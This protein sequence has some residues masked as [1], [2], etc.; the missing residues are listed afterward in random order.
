MFGNDRENQER[1]SRNYIES[2]NDKLEN[3]QNMVNIL[4]SFY[5]LYFF[6]VIIVEIK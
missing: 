5:K 1:L 2:I 3:K 4:N 6:N